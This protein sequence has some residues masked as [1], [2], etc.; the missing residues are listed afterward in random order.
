MSNKQKQNKMIKTTSLK[1]YKK[2]RANGISAQLV[3]KAQINK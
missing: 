1:H 3:T 2:L